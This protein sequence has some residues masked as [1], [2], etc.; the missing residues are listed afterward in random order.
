MIFACKRKE[1][2][3]FYKIYQTHRCVF[4]FWMPSG[5]EFLKKIQVKKVFVD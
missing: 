2:G 5:K 3:R 4:Q 1:I